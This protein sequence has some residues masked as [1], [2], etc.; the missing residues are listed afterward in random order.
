MRL[1]LKAAHRGLPAGVTDAGT[2]VWMARAGFEGAILNVRIN[3]S[4]IKDEKWRSA[5]EE[6]ILLLRKDAESLLEQ[7]QQQLEEILGS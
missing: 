1:A 7:C 5:I 4:E 2:A 6:R 3:L